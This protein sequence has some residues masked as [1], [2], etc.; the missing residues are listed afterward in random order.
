LDSTLIVFGA[1]LLAAFT[2]SLTGFGSA[3]VTMAFLPAAL[4]IRTAQPLVALLAGTLET[5]LFLRY[6]DA[7][8]VAAVWRLLVGAFIAIPLGIVGARVIDERIV[9]T[10]LGIVLV[11][12]PLYALFTPTLPRV[13]EGKLTFGVGFIAGLLGGAYNTSGPPVIVYAHS[14]GWSPQEFKANLQAFFL[15]IDTMTITSHAVSGNITPFVWQNFLLILP[16][17]FIGLVA[18][19]ALDRLLN[20]ARFRNIVLVML[21]VLG[22]R[23]IITAL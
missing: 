13:K 14:R 6:R 21:I 10:M 11:I 20:P 23:M 1:V 3:L 18:G 2:Q 17:I 22:L 4:G 15:L 9:L 8:N 5:I 19:L 16:A 7:I 12:Y